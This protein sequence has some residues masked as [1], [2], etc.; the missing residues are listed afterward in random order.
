M[1]KD[2]FVGPT[3]T[4]VYPEVIKNVVQCRFPEDISSKPD[5]TGDN[6]S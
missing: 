2:A 1:G 6:V 3:P 5:P 4:Y